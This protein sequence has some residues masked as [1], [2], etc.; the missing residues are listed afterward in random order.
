MDDFDYRECII[1]KLKGL[2]L[3]IES[4]DGYDETEVIFIGQL[5]SKLGDFEVLELIKE[6]EMKYSVLYNNACFYRSDYLQNT[7]EENNYYDLTLS[8]KKY[9]FDNHK[10]D[11]DMSKYQNEVEKHKALLI[12]KGLYT[13]LNKYVDNKGFKERVYKR[14]VDI[15]SQEKDKD[16]KFVIPVESDIVEAYELVRNVIYRL[17]DNHVKYKLIE[18]GVI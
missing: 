3:Q 13:N 18:I 1:Q 6:L 5:A 15:L 16:N 2:Y 14:L 11:F 4:D 8:I 9:V 17:A 10:L 12:T 7:F